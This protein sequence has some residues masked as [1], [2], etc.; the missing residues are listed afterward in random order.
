M[1]NKYTFIYRISRYL[2]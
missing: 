2:Y 1:K